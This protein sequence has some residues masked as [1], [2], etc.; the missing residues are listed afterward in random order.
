MN[1]AINI[2]LNASC[3]KAV[4][5]CAACA[6]HVRHPFPV[7]ADR[8]S[9]LTGNGSVGKTSSFSSC[10]VDMYGIMLLWK[11]SILYLVFC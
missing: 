7:S 4:R 11:V 9:A 3:A 5:L 10:Q 1:R 6:M 8:T 2:S